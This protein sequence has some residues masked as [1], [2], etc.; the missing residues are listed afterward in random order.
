MLET[1]EP[2]TSAELLTISME[3]NDSIIKTEANIPK[4]LDLTEARTLLD[5]VSTATSL[6]SISSINPQ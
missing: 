3:Q 5:N 2:K 1:K 4:M 6:V